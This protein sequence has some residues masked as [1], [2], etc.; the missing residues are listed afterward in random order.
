MAGKSL[1]LSPNLRGAMLMTVSTIGFSANDAV[2]KLLSLSMNV[3]Q[4]M[5]VRG[6]LATA[7][8]GLLAWRARA[9]L[10]ARRA[11]H[12]MVLLRVAAEILSTICF[13]TALPHL[14]LAN[15]TA[16]M[17]ALPLAVTMAAA[18]FLAEPVG[19]RRWLSILAGFAGVLI[20]VRPGSEGFNAYALLT[21]VSVAAC[22]V[23][24]LATR[25]APTDIP[26]LFM[27]FVTSLGVTLTGGLLIA[28]YGG[29]TPLEPFHLAFLTL[30]AALLLV[31]Y[32]F[33]IMSNRAGDISFI[34]PFRYISLLNAALLGFLVFREVP[35]A[36]MLAGS[37]VIVLSGLY[38]L[39]R[40]RIRGRRVAT[41][42]AAGSVTNDGL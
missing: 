33:L 12:P 13:L 24:D 6:V 28:P 5:L 4:I 41:S 2:T 8:I 19:W 17:Q 22:A 1:A 31:G 36:A 10:P 39:Y 32:Q 25:A 26:S 7:L 9:M 16:I 38:M 18:L 15:A 40:E 11:L 37:L 14:A 30:G 35:D 42:V 27:T 34:A 3:A 29:W 23:R 20:I 21:L